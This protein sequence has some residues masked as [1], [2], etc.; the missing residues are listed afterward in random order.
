MGERMSSRIVALLVALA[1]G[2]CAHSL[3]TDQAE[4]F[5]TLA[6]ANRDSFGALG[7]QE[8][9]A[10]SA[11]IMREAAAGRGVVSSEHCDLAPRDADRGKPCA[12]VW[13]DA[14]SGAEVTLRPTAANARAV[15][16][17]LSVYGDQMATLAEAQ[18]IAQAQASVAS[19]GKAVNGLF[20]AVG[21]PPIGAVVVDALAAIQKS[22]LVDQRRE[23]LLVAAERADPA[24]AL[25]S[26][27]MT[28]IS[29]RLQSNLTIAASKRLS[30]AELAYRAPVA[31]ETAAAAQARRTAA[32]AE[33]VKGSND[34][35]AARDLATDYSALADAHRKL[36]AAL[37]RPEGSTADAIADLK[38]FLGL[39]KAAEGAVKEPG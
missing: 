20:A 13:K 26:D 1:I 14:R 32:L 25:A 4:A 15:I 10:V 29:R 31:G 30:D 9:E 36:I 2:G 19:V 35:Q 16:G 33:M 28:E 38:T 7:K 24:V 6:T 37:R 11:L 18:D 3:P 27:R 12:L 8:S 34:L 5:R 21:V 23:V 17:A 22:R 39:L